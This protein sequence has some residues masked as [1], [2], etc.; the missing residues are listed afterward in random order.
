MD[1]DQAFRILK[2]LATDLHGL[3]GL[4]TKCHLESSA[5]R[6]GSAKAHSASQDLVDFL[7]NISVLD[8]ISMRSGGE[9]DVDGF[10]QI[11]NLFGLWRGW[12]EKGR[13]GLPK[14]D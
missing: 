13:R 1:A 11:L 4:K 8:K 3:P 5:A 2:T 14:W 6:S 12:M 7:H 9:A 10:Y